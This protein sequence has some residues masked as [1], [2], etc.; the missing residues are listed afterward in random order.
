LASDE[1]FIDCGAYDGD[2]IKDF[3]AK[4]NENFLSIQAF[5]PDPLNFEKLS[6]F[7]NSL[8]FKEK[9][10]LYQKAVGARFETLNFSNTGTTSSTISTGGQTKVESV[11]LDDILKKCDPT[12]IKMDIEGA[13][14][15]AL[16]GAKKTIQKSLPVLAICV[17]HQQNHLWKIPLLIK[18]FSQEYRLFLR[19]HQEEGWDLVCYAIPANRL[20][21]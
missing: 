13:E 10:I 14:I 12:F 16:L 6:E 18:S 1:I 5:E 15:D 11:P 20:K 4:T 17:Y 19:A 3:L 21:V 9:I 2:T 7:V 8:S